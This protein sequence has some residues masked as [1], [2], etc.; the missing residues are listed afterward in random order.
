MGMEPPPSGGC[1]N[2]WS[3][4]AVPKVCMS[5]SRNCNGWE[6][7]PQP[8]KSC[9]VPYA[10]NCTPLVHGSGASQKGF[11][12]LRKPTFRSDGRYS[13]TSG[14]SLAFT[15]DTRPPSPGTNL[16]FPKTSS[17]LR[18]SRRTS[19]KLVVHHCLRSALFP[20]Q[21]RKIALL[22]AAWGEKKSTTSSS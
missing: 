11:T 9:G 3:K 1:S 6:T 7:A 10:R 4:S 21:V 15:E 2:G 8:T 5:S 17:R 19:L 18:L 14:C 16:T 12:G 22:P 20:R 13:P